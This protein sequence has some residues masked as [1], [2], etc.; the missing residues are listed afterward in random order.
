MLEAA[1]RM[2]IAV[3]ERLSVIGFDDVEAAAYMGL[4]TVRQPLEY[5]GAR[6]ARLLLDLNN[7]WRAEEPVVE[8][9]PLELVRRRSTAPPPE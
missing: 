8:K 6:G 1:A 7:G 4:T 5:S 2:R 3:P 9:L